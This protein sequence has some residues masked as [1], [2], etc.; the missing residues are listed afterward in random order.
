MANQFVVT[1]TTRNTVIGAAALLAVGT[2]VGTVAAGDDS[3]ITGAVQASTLTTDGDL[4]TRAAGV[5]ARLGAGSEGHVLTVSSGVPA[6]AAAAGG[7]ETALPRLALDGALHHW[8]LDESGSPFADLGS[9]PVDLAYVSGTREYGRAG[10]Y[11][12]YGATLQRSPAATDRAEATVADI[13]SATDF[14]FGITIAHE[15]GV[16]GSPGVTTVAVVSNG[17][18]AGASHGVYLLTTNVG[19]GLYLGVHHGG[20]TADSTPVTIDWT[21]PHRVEVTY[22]ALSR[23]ATLYLDGIAATSAAP[24]SG[25]MDALTRCA[26]GGVATAFGGVR[27]SSLMAADFTVHLSAL[28]AADVLSR[29]DVCRRLAAG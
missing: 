8:R 29:A 1:S 3:R 23:T 19:P 11:A 22:V 20:V 21:R 12:R 18:G 13:P 14:T 25:T 26:V 16:I 7:G 15:T 24:A 10:L 6:W 28:S 17:L 9:S 2:T 5:P 4:L 27:G